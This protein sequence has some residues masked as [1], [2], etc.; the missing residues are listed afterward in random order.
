MARIALPNGS[1]LDVSDAPD[2]GGDRDRLR[3]RGEKRRQEEIA[4][5]LESLPEEN[6]LESLLG[7]RD[8]RVG[9]IVSGHPVSHVNEGL[10]NQ[11]AS[12]ARGRIQ[13]ALEST[14]RAEARRAAS[15]RDPLDE[16]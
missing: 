9:K 1:F 12:R 5:W 8:D 3:S 16:T 11:L 13:E 2:S 4:E 15:M 6:E 7:E 10:E 14:W